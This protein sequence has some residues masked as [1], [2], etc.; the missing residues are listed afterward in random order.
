VNAGGAIVTIGGALVAANPATEGD[1]DAAAAE[2]G[3]ELD[4][5]PGD[6]EG[7]LRTL[8]DTDPRCVCVDPRQAAKSG[9]IRTTATALYLLRLLRITPV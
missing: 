6:M 5:E 3:G 8:G 4:A 9:T 7:T 1:N 2:S